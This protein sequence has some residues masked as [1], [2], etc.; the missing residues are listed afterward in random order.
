MQCLDMAELVRQ[1]LGGDGVLY[2][3]VRKGLR[4]GGGRGE[5]SCGRGEGMERCVALLP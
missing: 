3:R 1:I 4:V 2:E 5:G